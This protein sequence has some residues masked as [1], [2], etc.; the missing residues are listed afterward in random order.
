MG[1][2]DVQAIGAKVGLEACML[3][4]ELLILGGNTSVP[5]GTTPTPSWRRR[6]PAAASRRR[7]VPIA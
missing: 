3:G 2:D 7:P 5:L 1:F 4:E 6:R